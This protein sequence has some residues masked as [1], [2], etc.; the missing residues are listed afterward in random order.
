MM[1]MRMIHRN[2]ITKHQNFQNGQVRPPHYKGEMLKRFL[3]PSP[4]QVDLLKGQ[5]RTTPL[6]EEEDG[7][8]SMM[9]MKIGM[10]PVGLHC[11]QR[12]D[13][14]LETVNYPYI[15]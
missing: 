9:R 6:Y 11:E 2:I 13:S 4:V 10:C 5:Q 7:D 12:L 1:L 15:Y 3:S 8:P 14:D